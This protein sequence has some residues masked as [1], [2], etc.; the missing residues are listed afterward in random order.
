MVAE[1]KK[2]ETSLLATCPEVESW[3]QETVPDTCGDDLES[4]RGDEEAAP[5]FVG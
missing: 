2:R 1:V 3:C 5:N 4:A